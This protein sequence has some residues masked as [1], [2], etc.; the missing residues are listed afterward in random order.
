MSSQQITTEKT[1]LSRKWLQSKELLN[2]TKRRKQKKDMLAGKPLGNFPKGRAAEQ[3]A[4]FVGVSRNTLKKAEQIVTAAEQNPER[5]QPLL[6][7]I[8]SKQLS[9]DKAHNKLKKE[10]KREELKS[11]KTN[12]EL[13]PENCKLFCNDFTK[14][15]S[16]T[17][18]DNSIDLIFTDPPYGEQSLYLY[19]DLASYCR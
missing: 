17:I 8:D 9:V 5:Y 11:I 12:I 19:E 3:L 4:G 1:G 18:P 14:I 13:P 7:K 16:E 15:D 10:K 2:H 6:D